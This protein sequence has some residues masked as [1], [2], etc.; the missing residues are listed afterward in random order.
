MLHACYIL[1]YICANVGELWIIHIGKCP[2]AAMCNYSKYCANVW[3][4]LQPQRKARKCMLATTGICHFSCSLAV[5][6]EGFGQCLFSYLSAHTI[7]SSLYSRARAVSVSG[8]NSS[9]AH[10]FSQ[11]VDTVF[12]YQGHNTK[13]VRRF[14]GAWMV[15][16]M[17]VDVLG[18][19]I[20]LH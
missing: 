7:H 11:R 14:P 3:V 20:T 17:R 4:P 2:S 5:W 1:T 18:L 6:E 10:T 12:F 15:L 16:L 19:E 9:I 13:D 8:V